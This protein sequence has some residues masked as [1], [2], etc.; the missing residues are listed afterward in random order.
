MWG[1][2]GD[3]GGLIVHGVLVVFNLPAGVDGLSALDIRILMHLDDDW[4][5]L[6]LHGSTKVTYPE[7]PYLMGINSGAIDGAIRPLY[8]PPF[9][10]HKPAIRAS[11]YECHVFAFVHVFVVDAVFTSTL[12]G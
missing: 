5:R 12:V 10:P 9:T 3:C 7:I 2:T 1:F 8:E 11:V 4:T 6:R